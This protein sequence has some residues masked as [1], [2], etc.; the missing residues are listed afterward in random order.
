M[1]CRG[2]PRL[3][4]GR[5]QNPR[6]RQLPGQLESQLVRSQAAAHLAKSKPC[7]D[8]DEFQRRRQALSAPAALSPAVALTSEVGGPDG[9]G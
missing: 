9:L 3:G 2:P 4:R 1:L 5:G 8:V 6:R 7:L